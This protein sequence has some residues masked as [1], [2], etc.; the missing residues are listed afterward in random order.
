MKLRQELVLFEQHNAV[1]AR[2]IAGRRDTARGSETAVGGRMH[3]VRAAIG[4]A[5]A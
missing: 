5:E 2:A 3:D 4:R 1:F